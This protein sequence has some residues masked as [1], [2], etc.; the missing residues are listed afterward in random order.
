LRLVRQCTKQR[1]SFQGYFEQGSSNDMSE[2]S[3]LSG[4][5]YATPG[6][7]TAPRVYLGLSIDAWKRIG[8]LAA[9]MIALFWPNLRRLWLKTNPF[10]GEANWG[11][12]MFIP[13]I[14]LYY[15]Y[16]NREALLKAP[17]KTAWSGLGIMLLGLLLFAYGIWPGQNDFIKDFAMVVTL[18]GVV[19]LMCGWKVMRIAWFPI[20]FLVCAIPWPGLV[21][22]WVAMPLQKAA[23][24]AAA[25]VLE[26]TGVEAYRDGTTILVYKGMEKRVLDVEEACA[27]LKSLMTFISVG[28]AVGFLSNRPLWQKIIITLSAIPIAVFCNMLR[29]TGVGVIDHYLTRSLSEGFAHQFVGMILLIPAFLLILLVAWVLDKIFVEEADKRALPAP[30][31]RSAIIEIPRVAGPKG[32][33][34]AAK[35]AVAAA[36]KPAPAAA[37]IITVGPKP[38]LASAPITAAPITSAPITAPVTKAPAPKPAAKPAPAAKPTPTPAPAATDPASPP[39]PNQSDL[40]AATMRLSASMRRPKPVTPQKSPAPQAPKNEG[41]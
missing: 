21:Y 15:L 30:G 31:S 3:L 26:F 25:K 18:F 11:H 5:Q 40:A 13:I 12:A 7:A 4:V 35:P 33:A 16:L 39:P 2:L 1:R 32:P 19:T 20:V 8:V 24:V 23:A 28:A 36:P 34:P 22:S 9:L 14:G 10:T 27:G 17:I 37:P 38:A 41:K 6:T 29:V